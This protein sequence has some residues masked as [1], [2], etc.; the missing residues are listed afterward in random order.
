MHFIKGLFYCGY[1]LLFSTNSF[2]QDP[3][4]RLT[5]L[6]WSDYLDPDIVAEFEEKFDA[7]VTQ[8]YYETDEQRT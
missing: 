5:I 2:A 1:L 8:I 6:N 4:N 3:E 7:Q